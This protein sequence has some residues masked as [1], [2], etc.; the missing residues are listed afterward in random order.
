MMVY[1]FLT[2]VN[3][4]IPPPAK[5]AILLTVG[6]SGGS[7]RDRAVPPYAGHHRPRG[8][9][10]RQNL[11]RPVGIPGVSPSPPI[12]SADISLP[13][14]FITNEIGNS[15]QC[16]RC[17]IYSMLHLLTTKV[18]HSM[19]FKP[20]N[21]FQKANFHSTFFFLFFV[22]HPWGNNSALFPTLNLL[23]YFINRHP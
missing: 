14:D 7:L 16:I 11:R 3:G 20:L 23:S 19:F 4:S 2:I 8:L 13:D 15:K 22:T 9:P 18:M 5:C 10:G 17:E 6:P 1:R 21:L 12:G